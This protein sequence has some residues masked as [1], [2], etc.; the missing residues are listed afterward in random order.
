MVIPLERLADYSRGIERI[1][2]EQSISNKLQIMRA[3]LEYLSGGMPEGRLGEITGFQRNDAIQA[4]KREAA[5]EAGLRS[6]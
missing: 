3:V 1:N 5:R 6:N 2:I 4:S